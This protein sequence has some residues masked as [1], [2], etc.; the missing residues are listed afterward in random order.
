MAD[1]LYRVIVNGWVI[2]KDYMDH[3]AQWD[4]T[5]KERWD[6]FIVTPQVKFKKVQEVVE[7]EPFLKKVRIPGPQGIGTLEMYVEKTTYDKLKEEYGDIM[8][9]MENVEVDGDE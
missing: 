5:M 2:K 8:L 1:Q 3:P 9:E 7:G 4:W 6:D